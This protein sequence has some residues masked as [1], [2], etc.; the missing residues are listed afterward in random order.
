M[1]RAK[2]R[3]DGR[4]CSQIYL[5]RDENGKRKYK[6]VYAKTPAELKE[7]ETSVRLQLGQG[8]DVLSQRDSFATWADDWAPPEGEGTDHLPTDGQLP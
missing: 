2:K 5:G 6:S 7:K 3:A 4:Y 1:A 8:L